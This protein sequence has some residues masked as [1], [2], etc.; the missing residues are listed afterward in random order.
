MRIWMLTLAAAVIV[1]G[2][3]ARAQP[4]PAAAPAPSCA[5][6][7]AHELDFWVGDWEIHRLS[8]D[9]LTGQSHVTR[10]DGCVVR[11]EWKGLSETGGSLNAY[12]PDAKTWRRL[13]AGVS[14]NVG[15][16]TGRWAGDRME[17]EGEGSSQGVR[18]TNRLSLTPL[19]DGSVRQ[20]FYIST[21]GKTWKPFIAA[22]YR[23]ARPR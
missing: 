17:F 11:E 22:V 3:T 2:S 14:A 12:D 5:D 20:Q 6:P 10:I 8:D 19:P 4:A 16:Y 15:A 9:K 13:W 21:D 7:H 1:M 23:P 18:V